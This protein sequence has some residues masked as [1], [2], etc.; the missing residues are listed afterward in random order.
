MAENFSQYIL[1][2]GHYA[3][4]IELEGQ[5]RHLF[6]VTICTT[7][8]EETFLASFFLLFKRSVSLKAIASFWTVIVSVL[9]NIYDFMYAFLTHKRKFI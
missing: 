9:Q 4:F 8:N 7:E 3:A 5:D 1:N 6:Y 2:G